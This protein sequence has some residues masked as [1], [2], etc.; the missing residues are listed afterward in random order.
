MLEFP[1]EDLHNGCSIA[2]LYPIHFGIIFHKLLMLHKDLNCFTFKL[3]KDLNCLV[4]LLSEL[5]VAS[6]KDV[7]LKYFSCFKVDLC[8]LFFPPYR[9]CT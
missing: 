6:L 3:L 9:Y 5:M 8:F 7:I 4:T 1:K 2:N